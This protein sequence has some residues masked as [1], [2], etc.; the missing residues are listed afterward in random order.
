ML[1]ST[2]FSYVLYR[3]VDARRTLA[4]KPQDDL[5]FL[6]STPTLMATDANCQYELYHSNAPRKP[7]HACK[8][9][10]LLQVW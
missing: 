3:A 7:F 10:V 2:T 5:H 6:Y 1:Y 9:S 8:S 4:H